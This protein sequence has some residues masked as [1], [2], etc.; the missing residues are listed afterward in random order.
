MMAAVP[1]AQVKQVSAPAI[2]QPTSNPRSPI[3]STNSAQQK[4]IHFSYDVDFKAQ[5]SPQSSG[6]IRPLTSV[7]DPEHFGNLDPHPDHPH[8]RKIGIWIRIKIHKLDPE[9]DTDL[10]QFADVKPK[11]M[12]YEPILALFQG[13]EPFFETRIWTGSESASW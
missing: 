8:Q 5:R 4:N 1:A 6:Q 7:V 3:R 10:H 11:C 12:E 2:C 13:F 9:P